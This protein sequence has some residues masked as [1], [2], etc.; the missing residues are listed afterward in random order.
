M[1][2]SPVALGVVVVA[3]LACT[4]R[5]AGPKP[6]ETVAWVI[7]E[8]T[9]TSDGCGDAAPVVEA[10]ERNFASGSG[11]V[12]RTDADATTAETLDCP[13]ADGSFDFDA[14]EPGGEVATIDGDTVT[15]DLEEVVVDAG[16]CAFTIGELREVVDE[17]LE[18]SMSSLITLAAATVRG[19]QYLFE[20]E[21][22]A[23]D[24]CAIDVEATLLLSEAER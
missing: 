4:G 19:C 5:R 18:G 9:V 22:V 6:D 24:G 20:G 15:W 3:T 21:P 16:P 10:V 17:G 11:F 23:P 12:Y 2:G 1:R 14:C 13:L 8:A 7:D